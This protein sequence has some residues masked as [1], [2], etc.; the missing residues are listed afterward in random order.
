MSN[1]DWK[2]KKEK[3]LENARKDPFLKI[4]D[5]A[6]IAETTPRYVRTILS[7]ANMSLMQLRKEY[8]RKMENR[9]NNICEKI[10]FNYLL[11]VPFSSDNQILVRDDL[12]FNK[13][14]DFEQLAGD[15]KKNYFYQSY[16]HVIRDNVPWCASTVLLKMEDTAELDEKILPDELSSELCGIL[17]DKDARITSVDL[18]IELSTNQIADLLKISPLA[19][20]FRIKQTI[21]SD[22]HIIV[23]MLLYFNYRQVSL[24]L[25]YNNGLIINRKGING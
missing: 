10:L 20:V 23:L 11:N 21:E 13:P 5:L 3:I 16:L 14:D 8:A 15:I 9:H 4:E 1:F 25:S 12:L 18:E 6:R 2:T 19:P 22:S 7:E 24:S 17:K